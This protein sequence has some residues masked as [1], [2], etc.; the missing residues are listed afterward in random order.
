MLTMENLDLKK[1]W[2]HLYQ[3]AAG[4]ITTVI[5][6]PPADALS[7]HAVLALSDSAPSVSPCTATCAETE[8][9]RSAAASSLAKTLAL[10][11]S[12]K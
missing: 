7:H 5:V 2:K 8:P 12:S 6:P 10:V 11:V 4:E 3:P 1:Q 9:A